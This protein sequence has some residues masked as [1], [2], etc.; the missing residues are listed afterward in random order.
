MTGTLTRINRLS[1][2]IFSQ[3]SING[4]NYWVGEHAYKQTDGSWQ[5]IIINGT[6]KCTRYA[7]PKFGYDVFIINGVPGHDYLEIHI[8][9]NPQVDSIGCCLIGNAIS[10]KRSMILKSEVAFSEFMHSMDGVDEFDLVVS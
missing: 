7:S 5:P 9:N 4:G 10:F 8:G 3:L 2:G 1:T 6:Y